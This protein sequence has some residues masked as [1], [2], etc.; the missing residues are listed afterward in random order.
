MIGA[1]QYF[2]RTRIKRQSSEGKPILLSPQVE[3]RTPPVTVGSSQK[4]GKPVSFLPPVYL[5]PG[6]V[7][8]HD[9]AGLQSIPNEHQN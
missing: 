3:R 6:N 9:R 2:L 1:S 8:D 5:L 7:K 4:D